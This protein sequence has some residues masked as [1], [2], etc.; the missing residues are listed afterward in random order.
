ML[1]S[2]LFTGI[3][4][5]YRFRN[6]K[7]SNIGSNTIYKSV[8]SVFLYPHNITI[9]NNVN[10]GPGAVFDGAGKIEIGD[11]VIFGPEVIIY[12]RNHNYNSIDLKSL[13]YD[14]ICFTS[15]VVIKDYVWIGSRVIILPGVTIGLG[16]VIGAGSVISRD[17]PDFA[18][19]IGNPSKIIK[20]RNKDVFNTLYRMEKPFVYD[21]FGRNKIFIPKSN[22]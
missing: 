21:I 15:K 8:R 16:A 10:I 22:K 13:P 6:I 1:I 9:G 4:K 12:S 2:K 5:Y 7:F 17:I 14:N 11:G 3:I 19:A 18:V 20:F